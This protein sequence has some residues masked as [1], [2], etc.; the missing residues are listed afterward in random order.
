RLVRDRGYPKDILS[1]EP[2]PDLAIRGLV[3]DKLRGYILQL[4]SH[5]HVG[6]V[7]HGFQEVRG[8]GLAEY[9][10]QSR[11]MTTDRSALIDTLYALPEAFLYAALVD[12]LET[13]QPLVTHDWVRVYHDIRYAIDLAHLDDSLKSEIVANLDDYIERSADFA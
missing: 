10:T 3:L 5:R 4:D 2:R 11:R 8:E 13:T 12:Y 1:N 9:H 6:K 7:I